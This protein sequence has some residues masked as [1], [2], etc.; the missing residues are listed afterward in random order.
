MNESVLKKLTNQG[1]SI[2]QI[3][4]ETKFSR[5]NVRHWLGKFNL[6]T[7]HK[8]FKDNPGP[9]LSRSIDGKDFKICPQ[10]KEEKELIS[11]FYIT[12]EKEIHGWC[13][14][15]NNRITY[16]KQLARKVECVKYKGGKCIVCG[17]NKYVGAL[18]F[19]HLDPS[20]KEFNICGAKTFGWEKLKAEL[21]KCI[22]FCGNCH[23]EAHHGLIDLKQFAN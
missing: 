10:C 16:E 17:Y 6:K 15:C 4:K 20:K 18:H 11:G 8:S 3:A 19:H 23:A 1:L 22:L 2:A 5:G 12:K 9:R 21:D 14:S 7:I 13:K